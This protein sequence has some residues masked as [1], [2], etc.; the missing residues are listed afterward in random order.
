[1]RILQKT[2]DGGPDSTVDAYFLCEFKSL[3]SIA[4]LKFN[5]GTR[6]AY[7]THAFNAYTW[8]LTGKMTERRY[9]GRR[10][11]Y[12][13]SW[14]PKVTLSSYNHKVHAYE[15]SWALTIRGPWSKGWTETINDTTKHFTHNR[16]PVYDYR[17]PCAGE[18]ELCYKN[19]WRKLLVADNQ[20]ADIALYEGKVVI[21]EPA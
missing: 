7:H 15:T 18:L 1:M 3:F 5:K 8:F 6:E 9:Q 4:L 17:D 10:K 16:E 21:V 19:G 20:Y 2:K 13:F 12:F 14:K 11:Q